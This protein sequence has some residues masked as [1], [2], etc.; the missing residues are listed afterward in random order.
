MK[1]FLA[2]AGLVLALGLGHAT[3]QNI[4]KSL[5]GAQDPRGPVG[6]DTSNSA[7]FPGHINAFGQFTASPSPASC[8]STTS[9]GTIVGA[10]STDVAGQ[11]T[12]RSS[13]CQVFFGSPFNVAP[14]CVFAMTTT[15]LLSTAM[16]TT[17]T[18]MILS[19]TSSGTVYPY[20][21]IGN[22]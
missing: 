13:A 5:Q 20:I 9:P 3:A 17:T 6:L 1:R 11:I 14:N 2:I 22:Q 16:T 8:G 19:S 10:G 12:A 21:C 4:T 15:G 7:Y 18:G